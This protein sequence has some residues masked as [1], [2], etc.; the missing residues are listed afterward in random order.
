MKKTLVLSSALILLLSSLATGASTLSETE[1][2]D[3]EWVARVSVNN[4]EN[5]GTG[6]GSAAQETTG[7]NPG[8]YWAVTAARD[9]DQAGGSA[10]QVFST[11]DQTYDPSAT[12][13]ILELDIF[14]DAIQFGGGSSGSVT[15]ILLQGGTEF[16]ANPNFNRRF[17]SQ[18][19]STLSWL[20]LDSSDFVEFTNFS[21]N[22]DFSSSGDL[23]QF[24]FV[25]GVSTQLDNAV[26]RNVGFDNFLIDLREP[27]PIPL[28]ASAWLFASA[29]GG[30]GAFRFSRSR[31]GRR[32]EPRPR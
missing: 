21:S 8:P 27:P 9:P 3:E 11:W 26:L 15:P 22:P 2:N 32:N 20:E 5:G 13:G 28:P 25:F 24:G 17:F 16:I 1:F 18:S 19:W 14:L 31:K 23:I 10:T 29:V 6:S 12:G 7:G 30:L 4:P